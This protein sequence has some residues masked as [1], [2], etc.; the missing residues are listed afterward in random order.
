M[1]SYADLARFSLA[2]VMC[3]AALGKSTRLE[4][5]RDTLGRTGLVPFYL[6][7]SLA[8][9]LPLAEFGAA[10]ALV[11][12]PVIGAVASLF[13][14]LC[15]S[16]A[17][18][19]VRRR[20]KTIPCSCFAGLGDDL[21]GPRTIVRNVVFIALA[22]IV[23]AQPPPLTAQSLPLALAG[24]LIALNILVVTAVSRQIAMSRSSIIA[25]G[26]AKAGKHGDPAG[27][28]A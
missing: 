16:L 5:F 2:V 12:K 3:L 17:A 1:S 19:I 8:L 15:F 9:F 25:V 10:V 27:T 20:G 14:L 4:V 7:E 13:L 28:R 24:A 6:V 23:L 22:T 11:A 26:A 18:E 21:I